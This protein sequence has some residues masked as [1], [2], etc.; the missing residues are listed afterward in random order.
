MYTVVNRRSFN[1]ARMDETRQRAE[2]EFFPKL[3]AA[4]G[5]QGFYLVN[6]QENQI[7]VAISVWDDKAQADAF[8]A[9][10][11]SWMR[12]LDS[13]GHAQQSLR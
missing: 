9:A 5:F 2:K 7:N 13:L 12:T 10:N 11:E 6:D 4:K 1:P 8:F 3:Q